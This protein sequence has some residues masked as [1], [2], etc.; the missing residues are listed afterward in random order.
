V[1]G[2]GYQVIW[3]KGAKTTWRLI[4]IVPMY[5]DTS[6]KTRGD[7]GSDGTRKDTEDTTTLAQIEEVKRPIRALPFVTK[8]SPVGGRNPTDLSCLHELLKRLQDRHGECAQ[9]VAEKD[10]ADAA[11]AATVRPETPNML[12]TIMHLEQAKSRAEAAN[13]LAL[14]EEKDSDVPDTGKISS[15][16]LVAQ[17]FRVIFC[18]KDWDME[19]TDMKIQQVVV[20]YLHDHQIRRPPAPSIVSP[21]K[22]IMSCFSLIFLGAPRHYVRRSFSCW[23]TACSRVCGRGHGSNSCGPNLMVEGCTRTKQTFWTEDEFTVTT[24]SGIRNRDVRV[25]EIVVM[26]FGK[27]PG[28]NSCVEK[29][30]KLGTRK[31]EEYKGVRFGNGDCTLVV[32]VWLHRVDEDASGLT[33]EEWEPSADTDVSEAPVAMIVNSSELCTAGFDLREVIPLQLK[34]V[35]CGGQWRDAARS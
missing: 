14:E 20:L 29:Q 30:F 35:A 22:D 19:H 11:S 28:S 34:V 25:A 6:L 9:A 12:Q 21:C 24:S 27:V 32:D 7:D 26:K 17:H 1:C 23:C 16:M 33:F 13:K 15:A 2:H 5:F 8:L 10:T 4:E 18:N 31:Y 3:V